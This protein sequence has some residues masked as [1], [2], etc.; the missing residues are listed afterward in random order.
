MAVLVGLNN[1]L[2]LIYCSSLAAV[3]NKSLAL[4]VL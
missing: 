1:L 3:C 2:A 4:S